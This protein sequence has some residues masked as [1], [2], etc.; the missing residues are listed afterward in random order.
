MQIGDQLDAVALGHTAIDVKGLLLEYGY[1]IPQGSIAKLPQ[2]PGEVQATI[3]AIE[4]L[5]EQYETLDESKA[6]DCPFHKTSHVDVE[7]IVRNYGSWRKEVS[8]GTEF[9]VCGEC[10]RVVEVR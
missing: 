5:R 2:L 4:A 3:T 8:S 7:T 10:H 9:L 6:F 1:V